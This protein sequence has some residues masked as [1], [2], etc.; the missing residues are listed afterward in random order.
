MRI[1]WSRGRFSATNATLRQLVGAAY[2]L[3]PFQIEGGPGWF[4]VDRFNI[5]ATIGA[6]AVIVQTRG[7][8]EAIRLMLQTLLADRFRFVAHWEKKPQTIYALVKAKP[9]GELGPSLQKSNVDCG[10]LF[11]AR[12]PGDPSP[13]AALCGNQQGAGKLTAGSLR[14]T[15]LADTLE[16]LLQQV[17]VDRTGLDGAFNVDLTWAPDTTTAAGPSL[18]T[19]IQEQ[20]GLKLEATKAPVDVLV[21]DRADKPSAD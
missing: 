13:P 2:T 6:D 5:E 12:R 18:F 9:G 11:A 3:L 8:P 15:Q 21:V 20:L 1:I 19:A 16:S 4:D 7:M 14:M 17:G 10:A